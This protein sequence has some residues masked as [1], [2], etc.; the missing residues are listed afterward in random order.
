MPAAPTLPPPVAWRLQAPERDLPKYSAERP[1]LHKN[2]APDADLCAKSLTPYLTDSSVVLAP[3]CGPLTGREQPG[4]RVDR[5]P[6]NEQG[7]VT[8]RPEGQQHVGV[9]SVDQVADRG[10]IRR[11]EPRELLGRGRA[12]GPERAA[13][14]VAQVPVAGRELG[15]PNVAGHADDD[16]P[17]GQRGV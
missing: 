11:S 12:V 5:Q 8:R 7:D 14:V 6:R 13:A 17:S 9:G 1:I 15:Q 16:S 10:A 4:H 2:Q 3:P